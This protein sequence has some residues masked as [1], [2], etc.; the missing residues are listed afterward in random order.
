M[1]PNDHMYNTADDNAW[2]FFNNYERQNIKRTQKDLLRDEINN[3]ALKIVKVREAKNN[4]KYNQDAGMM[5]GSWRVPQ[6]EKMD[7]RFSEHYRYFLFPHQKR[8]GLKYVAP[9]A[10][11]ELDQLK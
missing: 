2:K 8:N 9:P 6:V 4:M 7:K 3:L 11:Q 1:P 10:G 5:E